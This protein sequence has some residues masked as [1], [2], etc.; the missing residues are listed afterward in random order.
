M[1]A[2]FTRVR[3]HG[4]GGSARVWIARDND[5]NREVALKEMRDH[6]AHDLLPPALLKE[7]QITSQL[8]HPNIVPVHGLGLP[9]RPAR[10]PS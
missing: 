2:R 3:L 9:V 4:E 1:R 7:A 6:V 5:L 10:L 8:E